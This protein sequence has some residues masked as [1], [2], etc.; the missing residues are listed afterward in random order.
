MNHATAS[1]WE[2]LSTGPTFLRPVLG[3]EARVSCFAQS[4]GGSVQW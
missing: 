2:L 4:G 3:A 1:S